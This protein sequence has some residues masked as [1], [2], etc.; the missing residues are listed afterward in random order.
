MKDLFAIASD[1]SMADDEVHAPA[2]HQ[3]TEGV[4]EVAAAPPAETAG[5]DVTADAATAGV[6]DAT[7][8]N[9]VD[10]D[11]D[12]DEEV[13]AE[14]PAA[15]VAPIA[16]AGALVADEDG[17]AAE[18][19]DD[20][21]AEGAVAAHEGDADQGDVETA[22]AGA[23]PEDAADG[24]ANPPPLDEEED[25]TCEEAVAAADADADNDAPAAADRVDA[26]EPAVDN[27]TEATAPSPAEPPQRKVFPPIR[28]PQKS[29]KAPVDPAV[30]VI[31]GGWTTTALAHDFRKSTVHI[32]GVDTAVRAGRVQPIAAGADIRINDTQD[33]KGMQ[34]L[35]TRMLTTTQWW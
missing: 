18:A 10:A 25:P 2:E 1:D 31:A 7:A 11:V 4:E 30:A 29:S 12:N 3:D 17:A 33:T 34:Q 9:A 13:Q 23:P 16:E 26:A 14:P 35:Y 8:S 6:E 28:L 20:A 5:E 15:A 19:D 22:T 21:P 24:D 27:S 32:N